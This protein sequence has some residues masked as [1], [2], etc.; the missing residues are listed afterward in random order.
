MY[1]QCGS[2]TVRRGLHVWHTHTHT[3]AH[4]TPHAT[5]THTHTHSHTHTHTHTCVCRGQRA[6]QECH[7]TSGHRHSLSPTLS[8]SHTHTHATSKSRSNT[9]PTLY[10]QKNPSIMIHFRKR[11]LQYISARESCNL[12]PQKSPAMY[13]HNRALL[14]VGKQGGKQTKDCR[15]LVSHVTRVALF[16]NPP[17]KA[18]LR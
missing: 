14:R 4:T 10:L 8:L 12:F 3:L 9:M 6:C 2:G 15:V 5:H 1:W 13:F 18:I 16:L 17:G 11:D 7:G